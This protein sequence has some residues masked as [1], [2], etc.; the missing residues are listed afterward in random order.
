MPFL[1]AT[2]AGLACAQ[3]T[4]DLFESTVR[5]Y[6]T[7]AK[8]YFDRTVSTD[9]SS[10]Y[11]RFLP[12]IRSRGR[13]LDVGCGSGRDLRQFRERGYDAVGVDASSALVQMAREYSGAPCYAL[14]LE[15]ISYKQCF[16]GVW[17]C[18]SLLHLQRQALPSVLKRIQQALVS[19]GV[20]FTSVQIGDGEA[21]FPDGRF[22]AYYQPSDFLPMVTEADFTV[23]DSWIT[24]DTLSRPARIRWLNVLAN[25]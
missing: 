18:A 13:L 21:I 4:A 6:D 8:D 15:D 20:L 1:A 19:G 17:A 9:L 2:G 22:Y 24:D 11:D 5:F 16:D 12:H 7:H 25:T 23:T 10:L 3:T 14:R